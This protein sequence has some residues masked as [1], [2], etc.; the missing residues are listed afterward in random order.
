MGDGATP[1]KSLTKFPG[2]V[3]CLTVRSDFTQH[4]NDPAEGLV[5][6]YSWL[7][8]EELNPVAAVFLGEEHRPIGGF[9][10]RICISCVIRE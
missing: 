1:Q 7:S 4:Q 6:R 10:E 5:F 3:I 2:L 8:S 9:N